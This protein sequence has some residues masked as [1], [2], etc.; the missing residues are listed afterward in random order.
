MNENKTLRKWA[1]WQGGG[2]EGWS[3]DGDGILRNVL[4][5]CPVHVS[6]SLRGHRLAEQGRAKC[7]RKEDLFS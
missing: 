1:G 4:T 7:P 2:S 3:R 6:D 5:T